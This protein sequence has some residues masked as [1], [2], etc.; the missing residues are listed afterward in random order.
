M[1]YFYLIYI[2]IINKKRFIIFKVI[3]II[4]ENNTCRDDNRWGLMSETNEVELNL[5]ACLDEISSH[6]H[7]LSRDLPLGLHVWHNKI[8]NTKR[9]MWFNC[10]AN[11]RS[12]SE[13]EVWMYVCDRMCLC[14]FTNYISQWV[15]LNTASLSEEECV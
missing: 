14:S 1:F 10:M 13:S 9:L 15:S 5:F 12:P 6:L 7:S 11:T 8:F 4:W 3:N 2:K